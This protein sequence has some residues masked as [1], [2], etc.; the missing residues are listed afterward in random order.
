MSEMAKIITEEMADEAFRSL[1][2]SVIKA[3][4]RALPRPLPK[5]SEP[6]AKP[7][8]AL[9][10]ATPEDGAVEC[11]IRRMENREDRRRAAFEE[12]EERARLAA[13]PKMKTR[14]VLVDSPYGRAT[15]GRDKVERVIDTIAA[16]LSRRL[17]NARQESA[18]RKVQAAYEMAPSAL[19]CAL[20]AGAGGGGFS[21]SPS[22]RQLW[23][24]H[25]LNEVRREIGNRDAKVVALVC[26]EGFTI[27]QTARRLFA[28][29]E[30]M[31]VARMDLDEIGRRLKGALTDLADYW[32]PEHRRA[33]FE[34]SE[35][36]VPRADAGQRPGKNHQ[37]TIDT[38]VVMHVVHKGR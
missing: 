36:A 15:N 32:W 38:D 19:R 35:D 22:E 29:P 12:A 27:E 4:G 31:P 1:A 13:R 16:L 14:P 30:N 21:S 33:R 37:R 20:A 26:G 7:E 2:A 17:I 24:G 3:D 18:A 10:L 28:V 5:S 34:R 8:A 23:A 6:R 25:V 9:P 11:A